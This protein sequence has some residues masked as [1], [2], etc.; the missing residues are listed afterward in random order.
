MLGED[1]DVQDITKRIGECEG[2]LETAKKDFYGVVG[3]VLEDFQKKDKRKELNIRSIKTE[4]MGDIKAIVEKTG[5]KY[6][7]REAS[8]IFWEITIRKPRSSDSRDEEERSS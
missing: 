1:E 8:K 6:T 3:E 2:K 5:L 7:I 4:L